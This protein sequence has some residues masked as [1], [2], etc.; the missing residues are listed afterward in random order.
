MPDMPG[1]PGNN[2]FTLRT[3]DDALAIRVNARQRKHVVV[4]GA[5]L[6]GFEAAIALKRLA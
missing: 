6:V 3:L 1:L 4:L 5:G 2:T